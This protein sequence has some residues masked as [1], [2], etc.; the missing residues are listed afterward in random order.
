MTTIGSAARASVATTSRGTPT[1]AVFVVTALGGL[2]VSLDVSVANALLP[3][4]GREFPGD[5][6]DALSWVI[7][8][9]AIVF[10][11]A[12]VPAGRVADRAGRRRTY[13]GGLTV[14]AAGS[15][16]CAIAPDL[17][18]LLGGRILQG[19]G[20]AAASPA[21]LGLLLASCDSR[22]RAQYAARWTGA[23]AVGVCLG[24]LV[25]GALTSALDWRWAFLVNLPI[26]A[27]VVVAA[28]RLLRE[29]P[30]HPGR[31]LPDP[32]GAVMFALAAAA[33]TLVLS[34]LTTWGALSVRSIGGLLAAAALS[35]A[36]VRRAAKVREPMLDLALLRNRRVAGSAAVAACYAA[37]FFGFLL[38]FI[39]F[40]VGHWHLSLVDAGAAVL[41]AGV[42][43]IALTTHVGRLADR[44][45]HRLPLIVGAALMALAL[46]LSVATLGGQRF[47][48]RWLGIGLLMGLG[49]G[50]VYP[51]LAGAAVHGLDAAHL[52]AA[53]AINQ[54]ARQLGAAVGVAAAVGILGSAPIPSLSRFHAAWVLA[55]LFCAAAAA[56][57]FL[58]PRHAS[59]LAPTA[60]SMS[61]TTPQ[62]RTA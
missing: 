40:F 19:L 42:V 52:A 48:A 29:T 51:V 62:E 13:V 15:L 36:F 1:T 17:D 46:L 14:F 6:R 57:A 5:G 30:R 25:G 3:A 8:G 24:P 22:H 58:I 45:G 34:E 53:T 44:V 43:V 55:A 20:A 11:A 49:I 37:G 23:A 7:T 54:C 56:A 35:V 9:Y 39:L 16:V 32:L 59:H 10:A 50:L 26:V 60:R 28:P 4:I 31:P 18:V 21:S 2:L 33:L 27:G 41:P 61:T 47:E 12:L 38:T